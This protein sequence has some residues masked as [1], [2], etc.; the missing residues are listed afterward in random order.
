MIPRARFT[1]LVLAGQVG[2]FLKALKSGEFAAEYGPVELKRF[3]GVAVEVEV[4]IDCC[5]E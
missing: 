3:G 2:N 1:V 5:H 4:G